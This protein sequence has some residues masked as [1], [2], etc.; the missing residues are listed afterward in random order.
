MD[1]FNNT[2]RPDDESS[3]QQ[4]LQ[5]SQLSEGSAPTG[6]QSEASQGA[7]RDASAFAPEKA[8]LPAFVKDITP[9]M[10]KSAFGFGFAIFGVAYGVSVIVLLLTGLLTGWEL[11]GPMDSFIGGPVAMLMLAVFGALSANVDFF[12]EGGLTIRF[13]PLFSALSLIVAAFVLRKRFDDHQAP[14]HIGSGAVLAIAPA[15]AVG[16]VTML[17]AFFFPISISGFGEGMEFSAASPTNAV[18]IIFAFGLLIFLAK[19]GPRGNVVSGFFSKALDWIGMSSLVGGLFLA[20]FTGVLLVVATVFSELNIVPWG[21]SPM[22][23]G[24]L[25]AAGA[26]VGSL[27]QVEFMSG[28][29]FTVGDVG[30]FADTFQGF[31]IVL[32]VAVF[33]LGLVLS[34]GLILIR[35]GG[36]LG[37]SSYWFRTP[38]AFA[39]IGI[40]VSV[41]SQVEFSAFGGALVA[42]AA[43]WTFAMFALWG[44]VAEALTR[45]VGAYVVGIVPQSLRVRLSPTQSRSA[46]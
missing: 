11:W 34:S 20:T 25:V 39:V 33:V 8:E 18:L 6:S 27:A 30:I 45:Y 44:L 10:W 31:E 29:V 42:S 28:S 41:V 12:L 22:I 43:D 2:A 14:S 17:V 7:G 46:D 3:P 26:A 4:F 35:R 38:L 37:E 15:V 19:T 9:D 36:R 40:I 21:L 5:D 32:I 24:V 13:V 23:A 16:V 1:T